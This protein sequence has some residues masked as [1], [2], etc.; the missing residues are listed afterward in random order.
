MKAPLHKNRPRFFLV[1]LILCSLLGS[2]PVLG[3]LPAEEEFKKGLALHKEKKYSQAAAIF[4]KLEKDSPE[5]LRA[6]ALFMRGQ[7]ARAL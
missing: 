6:E 7:G 4:E 1:E 5:N 2:A 3:E